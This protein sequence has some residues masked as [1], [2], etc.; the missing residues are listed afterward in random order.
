MMMGKH[1]GRSR[2]QRVLS[3]SGYGKNAGGKVAAG[4]PSKEFD[5]IAP[6]VAGV[7]YETHA[8]GNGSK[9]RLDKKSRSKSKK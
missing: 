2:V 8:G 6:H 4:A 7:E 5:H 3:K 1:K 9:S